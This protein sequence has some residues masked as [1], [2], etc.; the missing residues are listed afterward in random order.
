[1]LQKVYKLRSPIKAVSLIQFLV[2]FI[3]PS[4][5]SRP[6]NHPLVQSLIY[7]FSLALRTALGALSWWMLKPQLG[8]KKQTKTFFFSTETYIKRIQENLVTGRFWHAAVS[9]FFPSLL[10]FTFKG[11][12]TKLAWKIQEGKDNRTTI[13]TK[14]N[15]TMRFSEEK[16]VAL[17]G[18]FNDRCW[19]F[20]RFCTS[21]WLKSQAGRKLQPLCPVCVDTSCLCTGHYPLSSACSPTL[22]ISSWLIIIKELV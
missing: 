15:S 12:N 2:S 22:N 7:S 10:P 6:H 11:I 4:Q 5:H 20:S 1:M 3:C 17:H 21:S 8:M 16:C 13:L 19:I 9:Y 18:S 14:E